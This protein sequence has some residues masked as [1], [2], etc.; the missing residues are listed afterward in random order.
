MTI[1]FIPNHPALFISEIRSLVIADL[2]IGVEYQLY[3]SGIQI[4]SQIKQ[5][6]KTIEKLIEQ[7]K[8]KRLIILGDVKHDVPGISIQE[9]REIPEFLKALSKKIEI[10]ICLGNHDTYLKEILPENIKLHGTKGFRIGR[11]GFNHGH[12]WPSRELLMC[13]Y[14]I[15]AH[16][17]PTVQ[18]TDK[19]GYRIVEPVWI[20]SRINKEKI[21]KRYKLKKTGR[22]EIIIM[23][24]FNQLLG[25]TPINV[26]RKK[27]ELLGPLLK[28]N[29]LDIKN[30]ELYLLDGTYLGNLKNIIDST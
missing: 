18:F 29:F 8:A 27:N 21:R 2:H 12:T 15:I 20:K 5:M 16:T 9:M 17:H 25:G 22:L 10:D 3:K 24:A 26:R 1:K 11:F 13:D 23:P 7:T 14:L 28:N 30:A 6:R 19:F 4:P